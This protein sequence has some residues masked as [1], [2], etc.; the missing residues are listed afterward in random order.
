[1]RGSGLISGGHS[2]QAAGVDTGQ[3]PIMVQTVLNLA[4][5]TL[6]YWQNLTCFFDRNWVPTYDKVTLP[7]CFF[8]ILRYSEI[9]RAETSTK[10]VLMYEPPESESGDEEDAGVPLRRG[11]MQTIVDNVVLQPK[12]YRMEIVVPFMPFG[13]FVK[14]GL[15]SAQYIKQFFGMVTGES[16]GVSPAAIPFIEEQFEHVIAFLTKGQTAFIDQ[17][18]WSPLAEEEEGVVSLNNMVNKNSLDAMFSRGGTIQFKTWMGF[19]TK[20]VVITDCTAEKRGIE[21]DVWRMDMTVR[22]LPVLS[23][24]PVRGKTNVKERL[25]AVNTINHLG[26]LAMGNSEI[27]S[28]MPFFAIEGDANDTNAG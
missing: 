23:L 24:A 22:E 28:T 2:T 14:Q 8:Q 10:R 9:Q 15:F 21:D 1:M 13:R 19:E 7:F 20:Y 6:D 4:R 17:S 12:E 3:T 18:I 11:A 27:T 5:E 25:W 16:S 26:A